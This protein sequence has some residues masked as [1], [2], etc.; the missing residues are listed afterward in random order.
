MEEFS[1]PGRVT[2]GSAPVAE[3][4]ERKLEK[5]MYVVSRSQGIEA[6]V[7]ADIRLIHD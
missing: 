7:V 1:G 3:R 6:R 5:G 4:S 2:A